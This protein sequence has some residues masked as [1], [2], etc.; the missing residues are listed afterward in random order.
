MDKAERKLMDRY[1]NAGYIRERDSLTC[2]FEVVA[3]FVMAWWV[4]AL[5]H[6]IIGMLS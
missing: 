5:G 1:Q 2:D 6:S 3:V 4:N